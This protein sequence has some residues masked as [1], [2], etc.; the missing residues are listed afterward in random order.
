MQSLDFMP[1]VA[2]KQNDAIPHPHPPGEDF[3]DL[4]DNMTPLNGTPPVSKIDAKRYENLVAALEEFRDCRHQG[5]RAPEEDVEGTDR[6][7]E[8]RLLSTRG[9]ALDAEMPRAEIPIS[10]VLKRQRS[11]KQL[12]SSARKKQKQ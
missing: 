3:E 10:R 5:T 4:K 8:E 9:E 11:P 7:V 2:G 1:Q 12:S 6:T